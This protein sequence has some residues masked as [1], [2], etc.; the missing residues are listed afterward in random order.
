[1]PRWCSR[2][3]LIVTAVK[4]ERLQDISDTDCLCE[5]LTQAGRSGVFGEAMVYPNPDKPWLTETPRAWFR[6]LWDELNGPGSWDA[7]PYVV[8]LTF[9][10][11]RCNIDALGKEAA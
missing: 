6:Q 1:M 5:G 7:N 4:I 10:V 8:A 3:T 9:S 2:I 11:H